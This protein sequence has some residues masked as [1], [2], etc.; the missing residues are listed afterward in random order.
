MFA[1]ELL[2]RMIQLAIAVLFFTLHSRGCSAAHSIRHLRET[3]TT[4]HSGVDHRA[5]MGR[6]S[7]SGTSLG[8]IS[9]CRTPRCWSTDSSGKCALEPARRLVSLK[10]NQPR[11]IFCPR[12][13]SLQ[14]HSVSDR[15]ACRKKREPFDCG[16]TE[17]AILSDKE[18]E[19]V[20]LQLL[21]SLLSRT[22]SEIF[23]DCVAREFCAP[24][25]TSAV[26]EA[27]D[28]IRHHVGSRVRTSGASDSYGL[29]PTDLLSND[30]EQV[31]MSGH[32]HRCQLCSESRAHTVAHQP[33]RDHV[34]RLFQS[35]RWIT[36]L[37]ADCCTLLLFRRALL[38][39]I[40]V[41][42]QICEQSEHSGSPIK[43]SQVRHA[44]LST[45]SDSSVG[46]V[47][48]HQAN[49]SVSHSMI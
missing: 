24:Q 26:E 6:L 49:C 18:R 40:A 43:L 19:Q 14:R 41:P 12:K 9:S 44:F 39:T 8:F 3:T 36:P 42:S 25:P 34:L 10:R 45:N 13:F 7:L 33:L 32:D 35:V 28:L 30:K 27:L 38:V 37:R 23:P 2:V 4:C 21:S 11:L 15:T 20:A 1:G 16:E 5:M 29:L 48:W 47:L 22:E 46:V 31:P 17:P